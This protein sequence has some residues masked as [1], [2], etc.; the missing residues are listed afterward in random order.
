MRFIF[1]APFR[2]GRLVWVLLVPASLWQNG[3]QKYRRLLAFFQI[4][5]RIFCFSRQDFPAYFSIRSFPDPV[6]LG[7]FACAVPSPPALCRA[8]GLCRTAAWEVYRNFF[9]GEIILSHRKVKI[10]VNSP[11]ARHTPAGQQHAPPP[12]SPPKKSQQKRSR[13][14]LLKNPSRPPACQTLKNA[15]PRPA[16][17]LFPINSPALHAAAPLRPLSLTSP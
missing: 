17:P 10:C 5:S 8:A 11:A 7:R 14:G 6:F 2:L 9:R 16:S 4:E 12:A 3:K 1:Q 13:K 15:A